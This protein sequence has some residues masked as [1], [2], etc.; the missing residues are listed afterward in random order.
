MKK[1]VFTQSRK[2]AKVMIIEIKSNL[3]GDLAALREI[4]LNLNYK[5]G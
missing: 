2:G 4:L 1:D 3:L 5:F